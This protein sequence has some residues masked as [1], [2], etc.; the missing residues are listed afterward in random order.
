M[1]QV[2]DDTAVGAIEAQHLR[3]WARC[4]GTYA[5]GV[6]ALTGAATEPLLDAGGVGARTALLDVGTGPGAVIGPA[7]ARGASVQAVDLSEAMVEQVRHRHPGIDVRVAN[8]SAL[9]FPDGAFDAVTM[10]FS[11]HHMAEPVAALA[12]ARRVLRE[13]GRIA[14]TVWAPAD[15]L[16]VFG[17]GYAS[18]AELTVE[19][20][21]IHGVPLDVAEPD[22]VLALLA[23]AGFADVEVRELESAGTCTIP[24][25]SP[26]CS[27]ASSTE[28]GRRCRSSTPPPWPR[29]WSSWSAE[30]GH[31]V[32]RPGA[33]RQWLAADLQSSVRVP[34]RWPQLGADVQGHGAELLQ[35]LRIPLVGLHRL[36]RRGDG[37]RVGA[38]AEQPAGGGELRRQVAPGRRLIVAVG[39]A[40]AAGDGPERDGQVGRGAAAHP[41]IVPAVGTR[42]V[43]WSGCSTES[44]GARREGGEAGRDGLRSTGLTPDHLTITGLR[45]RRRR[46]GRHRHR[47]AARS[48]SCSSSSPP[49]PTCST[50]RWPRRP[51]PPASAAPSSTPSP[52]GSPTRC[53]SA[54]S[55]GTWP[56]RTSAA[57]RH[58]ARSACSALSRSSP[59]SGPRPS[60]SG[61]TPRAG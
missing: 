42:R 61:S 25:R 3:I 58:A 10:S 50:A 32:R 38:R 7:L 12:E 43:A 1:I 33:A 9:P 26:T 54:A 51:T 48:G 34:R 6:E 37:R 55:P 44:S 4:A 8:A 45:R 21:P 46:R 16:Q 15:R 29:P 5:A 27:T 13:G 47:P 57:H 2:V 11:L 53:C 40:Q 39:L 35:R 41:A 28:A 18:V 49:C 24:G 14:V 52:T 19:L 22:D 23:E 59:T 56:S 30:S 20:E 31:D 17:F 36:D 60:R